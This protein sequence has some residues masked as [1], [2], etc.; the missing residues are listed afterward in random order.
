MPKRSPKIQ[1]IAS[2]VFAILELADR[3]LEE[4]KSGRWSPT[5]LVKLKNIFLRICDVYPEFKDIL[6]DM[7][8]AE[9][10]FS[11]HDVKFS[12]NLGL[13]IGKFYG[14]LY[15][16]NYGISETISLDRISNT[17]EKIYEKAW[18]SSPSTIFLNLYDIVIELVDMLSGELKYSH[19]FIP[20]ASFE[21]V[22]SQTRVDALYHLGKL[23]GYL[24]EVTKK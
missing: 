16:E 14:T 10:L 6:K 7:D 18:Y 24:S 21:I 1:I 11:E 20:E 23:M 3:V 12:Y 5:P 13:A 22:K 15:R 8:K 4:S 2:D 17:I 19:V 9:K